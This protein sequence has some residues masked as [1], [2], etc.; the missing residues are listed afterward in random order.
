MIIPDKVTPTVE[1]RLID[2]IDQCGR[3]RSE[4]QRRYAA[5]RQ[6]YLFG[7]QDEVPARYNRIESHTEL[8]LSFLYA[9]EHIMLECTQ[10][11][12]PGMPMFAKLEKLSDYIEARGHAGGIWQA[13]DQAL[14]WSF[15]YDTMLI[16]VGWN[17]RKNMALPYLVDPGAFAVYDETEADLDAQQAFIHYFVLPRDEV[18]QRLRESGKGEM[19]KKLGRAADT[20]RTELSDLQRQVM[21]TSLGTTNL[22]ETVTGVADILGGAVRDAYNGLLPENYVPMRELWIYDDE[23]ADYR[24]FEIAYPDIIL[25][26]SKQ[27]AKAARALSSPRA[28]ITWGTDN[29]F[30]P[31]EHPFVQIT[32]YPMY[33]FFWGKSLVQRLVRLQNW[34]NVRLQ[35]IADILAQQVDPNRIGYGMSG[36]EDEKMFDSSKGPGHW[37]FE[38]NPPGA[39]KVDELRPPMPEDLFKEYESIGNIFMECIGLT[40]I[41]A[42]KGQ[43]GVRSKEL[44]GQMAQTGS[45]RIKKLALRLESMLSQLG[46]LI[47]KLEQHNSTDRISLGSQRFLPADLPGDLAV[48]VSGH[49]HSPVYSADT[50]QLAFML[51]RFSAIDKEGL[52]H[53]TNPPRKEILLNRLRMQMMSQG[54]AATKGEQEAKRS[55]HKGT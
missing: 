48:N 36:L 23:T 11:T 51:A 52:L 19:I 42:G 34:T 44:A 18:E 7:S 28:A 8:L 37:M 10:D 26:D 25:S 49:S 31:G 14:E 30:L 22:E 55:H 27:V 17:K 24:I 13:F 20:E 5:R 9:P 3:S 54:A 47:L 16:K 12:E 45:G 15:C 41:L 32:P 43:P 40:D 1:R 6:W 35:E 46:H 33:N 39:A 29:T 2:I 38:A 53:L 4:R 50:M 21:V